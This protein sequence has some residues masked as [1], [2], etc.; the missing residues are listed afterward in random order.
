MARASA[1][2]FILGTAPK[3]TKK[4]PMGPSRKLDSVASMVTDSPAARTTMVGS[5]KPVWLARNRHGWRRGSC[6]RPATVSRTQRAVAAANGGFHSR[7]RRRT[8]ARL[9]A[10]GASA[11]SCRAAIRL[12]QAGWPAPAA[13]RLALAPDSAKIDLMTP[14]TWYQSASTR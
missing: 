9:R 11:V 5:K 7:T 14:R 2:Y 1:V 12:A 3:Y 10:L 4:R 6:S 8:T 13:R